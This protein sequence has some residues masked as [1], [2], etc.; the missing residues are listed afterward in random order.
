M[1]PEVSAALYGALA[2]G[3]VAIASG[4]LVAV[5]ILGGMFVQRR[6]RARK[7][8]RCVISGWERRYGRPDR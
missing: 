3:V 4:V 7:K 1:N 6:L 2:G 5:G 8:V